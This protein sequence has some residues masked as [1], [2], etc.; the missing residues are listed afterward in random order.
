MEGDGI[1]RYHFTSGNIFKGPKV[2][3][4]CGGCLSA[5]RTSPRGTPDPIGSSVWP[6]LKAVTDPWR[7]HLST[8]SALV[9]VPSFM[10]PPVLGTA[11][12]FLCGISLSSNP[13]LKCTTFVQ[14]PTADQ[15]CLCLLLL[16]SFNSSLHNYLEQGTE[17]KTFPF[18]LHTVTLWK[19]VRIISLIKKLRFGP[20][21]NFIFVKHHT[22]LCYISN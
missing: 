15:L 18:Y 9:F 16:S 17:A 4:E 11:S 2:S 14:I 10:S 20:T 13:L 1:N 6:I 7:S 5:L 3:W 22:L 19:P 21:S 12:F 8:S